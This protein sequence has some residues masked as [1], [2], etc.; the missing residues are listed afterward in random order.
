MHT[1][2]L[3]GDAS[4]SRIASVVSL[5]CCMVDITGRHNSRVPDKERRCNPGM[6]TCLVYDE[7]AAQP[8]GPWGLLLYGATK[9]FDAHTAVTLSLYFLRPLSS[10]FSALAS[11]YHAGFIRLRT[12]LVQPDNMSTAGTSSASPAGDRVVVLFCTSN[13]NKL[14]EVQSIL[15]DEVLLVATDVDLP[16]LQGPS[17]SEIAREK[18]RTAVRQ[19]QLRRQHLPPRSLL[20]VEDTC[21]CFS[22]L[23]GLPGPYVK[24]FLK[25][26]GADG[27]PKLLAGFE[28][29]RGYALCTVCVCEVDARSLPNES[30]T[31]LKIHTFEGRTDGT[32][33]PEPRGPR[34]F[35]W[36]PI[37]KPDGFD[38]TYAEMDKSVKNT[39]SHRYKAMALLKAFIEHSRPLAC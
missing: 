7:G 27:L 9:P 17:P 26:L 22:A 2:V 13:Q 8:E 11:T 16:E 10:G 15:G 5:S 6:D 23:K 21:L 28:D 36:D 24:W 30:D 19:L 12:T 31:S 29:K 35:G 18:C 33:V 1:R 20:M 38:Q 37:F 25:N 32:I 14:T 3:R 4:R 39:I 34:D